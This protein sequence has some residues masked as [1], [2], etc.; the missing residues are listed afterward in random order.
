MTDRNKRRRIM[1]R[2]MRLGHCICN[3][4]QACPCPEFRERNICRCAGERPEDM[5]TDVALTALVESA[6]CASKISQSDLRRVL[7]GLPEVT[8]PRVL[9]GTGTCDDAGVYQLTDDLALVQSVDVFTPNVDDPYTFGQ[10][11]AANSLSD[12][13]AMGGQALTALAIIAFPIEDLSHRVMAEI[14]RGGMDKMA[15]AGVPVIGGHSLKDHETKFGFAVT[16]TIHP[17]RIITNAGAQVGDALVL[18]KPLGTGVI[19]FAA[20]V[21]RAS[22]EAVQAIAA[23]MTQL[24]RAAAEVMVEAGVHAATDVTGFGLMGHLVEMALG[25]GVTIEIVVDRVPRFAGALELLAEGVIAGGIE[26]NL[27]YA[28]DYEELSG[29]VP[30]P[31]R[32][33]MYDPQTSGGLLMAVAPDRAEALVARLRA[34][35]Y[36]HA[37]IIGRVTEPSEGQIILRGGADMPQEDPVEEPCC[38]SETEPE[39]E[40]ELESCCCSAPPEPCCASLATGSGALPALSGAVAQ[41]FGAFMNAA[42]ADGALTLK[43][44]ELIIVALSL[45]AKCEPCVRTHLKA[46]R[47]AGC[48]D[49]E[50]TE[51]LWLAVSMGGAPLLAF[52]NSLSDGG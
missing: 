39:I 21:G 40:V 50:I 36:A 30:E 15:E 24:N 48:S 18:T 3:P 11:A 12:V 37:A 35:G 5:P 32:L 14:I 1:E 8:N 9:V 13:Y 34:A 31:L 33:L 25:A 46:A 45:L 7:A 42:T 16:G 17:Q 44:K 4:R 47:E 43:Q 20:Q 38:S 23:S 10:I 41:R 22:G 51:A 49:A 26:R 29:E 6:G 27:E 28:E 19:S 52:Y 2:S